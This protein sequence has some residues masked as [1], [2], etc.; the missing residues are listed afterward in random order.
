MSSPFQPPQGPQPFGSPVVPP[1]GPPS[2]GMPLPP[3]GS[4]PRPSFAYQPAPR[5]SLPALF[6]L[7]SAL[8]APLLACFC[9][10]T[11]A[12]SLVAVVLGHIG[13]AQTSRSHDRRSGKGL[14]IGGLAIGYSL[15]L[16][17]AIGAVPFL[18]GFGRGF[19]EGRAAAANPAKQRMDDAESRIVGNSDGSA[20][21]NS[22]EAIALARKFGQT[23][24]ALRE[25]LFEADRKGALS[26]TGGNFVTYCELRPGK[27]VFLVHVP[28]Y[29]KF[30]DDAKESLADLAWMTAQ[31]A[32]AGTLQEG[33]QLAVGMKGT[34][35]YGSVMTGTVASGDSPSAGLIEEDTDD[36]R[37]ID[38]FQAEGDRPT[39]PPR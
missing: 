26:L 28:A 33:D 9:I 20:H 23:M 21:G 39:E 5:T 24:K 12:F 2:L 8:F 1:P 19:G 11:I 32:V 38:F 18:R 13:L 3:Y 27:C 15:L 25:E 31:R 17:S 37:L 30:T 22:D 34:L 4:Q 16:I 14:A 29:R 6:S 36:D 10:P 7:L 35:L